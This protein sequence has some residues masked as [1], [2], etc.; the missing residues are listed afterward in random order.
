M[1][2]ALPSR[3]R[4]LG[5]GFQCLNIRPRQFQG[6]SEAFYLVFA[7]P[8]HKHLLVNILLYLTDDSAG[9]T[10]DILQLSSSSSLMLRNCLTFR[11]VD[12]PSVASLDDSE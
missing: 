7:F 6:A 9:F 3:A 1:E 10:V 2:V 12:T 5:N 11:Q 4:I 8:L